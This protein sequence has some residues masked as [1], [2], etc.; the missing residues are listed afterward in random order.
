MFM[1]KKI[2][3]KITFKHYNQEQLTIPMYLGDLIEENHLVR[4]VNSAVERMNLKPLLERYEGGGTSC[5][6]PRMMLK[7]LVYAYS[8]KL[9]S[10]RRIA[11]ALRE[12]IY[13]MWLSG[14]NRP[15]F[16]TVNHFRSTVM[17]GIIEEVFAEVLELLVEDGYVKL[18]NYFV[19]GTKIEANANKYSFVWRKS[20]DNY[21]KKLQEKVKGLFEEIDRL[22]DEEDEAYGSEDLEERGGG[23]PIDSKKIEEKVN[24]INAKLAGNQDKNKEKELKK[25]LKKIETD[26]LP[27]MK[28]YEDYAQK[29]GN[30][31]SFSKTDVDATFMRMKED[32]MKNGQLK[33]GYNVQIG[34]ED[35]FIVGF[36]IHQRPADTGCLKPHLM[37]LKRLLGI[38]PKNIVADAGYGS[39]ENYEYIEQQELGNYVKYNTYH[40]EQKKKFKNDAFKFENWPYDEIEDAF[41]CPEGRTLRYTHTSSYTTEMGYKTERRYYECENCNGCTCREKCTKSKNNRCVQ[42]S[43]R[44]REFKR[45]VTESLNSAL[46]VILRKKRSIDVET[47]FGNIKGNGSFRRFMLRGLEKV[48][49]E[50]GLLSMAHNL[51]KIAGQLMGISLQT[52]TS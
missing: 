13:F 45:K 20:T 42:V 48:K 3:N 23:K 33:P 52:S 39:E 49:I 43:F 41:T 37:N 35:Q 30:R 4:V 6:H 28:K 44:L 16:R 19:D 5:Y 2:H 14:N 22:N 17:K 38:L 50:W 26:Y 21:K 8:Q 46:G 7:V 11:K 40:K 32:H 51:S 24:Q 47:V 12:N 15:D 27:R 31:N 1:K 34:T 10:S 29:L 25:H 18:E 9:Y 36:S